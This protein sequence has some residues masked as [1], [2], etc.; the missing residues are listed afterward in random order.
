M[1]ERKEG[2]EGGRKEDRLAALKGR[3][4]VLISAQVQRIL[5]KFSYLFHLQASRMPPSFLISKLA[6]RPYCVLRCDTL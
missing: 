2:T 5:K 3:K 4:M 6:H 1:S